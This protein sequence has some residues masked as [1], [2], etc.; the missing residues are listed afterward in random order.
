[1]ISLPS[2]IPCSCFLATTWGISSPKIAAQ[3]KRMKEALKH[4]LWGTKWF[5]LPNPMYGSW[6]SSFYD[7]DSDVSLEEISR[8]KF[9][10][11]R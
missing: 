10:Q 5:M 7:L 3:R 11:L 9:H 1:M 4:D 6:E 8:R 2:R